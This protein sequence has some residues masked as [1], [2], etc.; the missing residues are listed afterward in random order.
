MS[1][2]HLTDDEQHDFSAWLTQNGAFILAPTSEWEC[3]RFLTPG[4]VGVVY[5]TKRG[6]QTL[7]G[8]AERC[9]NLWSARQ[10]TPLSPKSGKRG[11]RMRAQILPLAERDGWSCFY[12]ATEL[13]TE[14]ATREHLVAVAA[15]GSDH[16][17]NLVLACARCNNMM[18]NKPLIEKIMLRDRMIHQRFETKEALAC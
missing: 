12:C 3:L 16:P 9:V 13:T 11:R 4:G 14:T 8:D 1:L 15:G 6:K 17:G 2:H 7:V 18:G 10:A 5:R